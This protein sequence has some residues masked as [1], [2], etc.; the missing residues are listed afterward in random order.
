MGIF[1]TILKI[2]GI[3][4]A[5]IVGLLLLIILLV[6][7]VPVTYKVSGEYGDKIGGRVK[8]GWLFASATGNIKKTDDGM[9]GIAKLKVFGIPIKK[10]RLMGHDDT[11]DKHKV[12]P[13]KEKKNKKSGTGKAPDERTETGINGNV[14]VGETGGK[15]DSINGNESF[16]IDG[17][18]DINKE[19]D[20]I[21]GTGEETP[22]EDKTADENSGKN[23]DEDVNKTSDE[24]SEKEKVGIIEKLRLKALKILEKISGTKDKVLDKKDTLIRKKDHFIEFLDK[25][26]T[27]NTIAR[28]KKLLKK[29]FKNLLPRKGN[30]NVLFGLKTPE[31]TGAMLGKVCMFYPL[32]HKW[33]HI[34]PEFYEKKIEADLWF[35]GRIFI[36]SMA[37]PALFL[38]LSKDFKRTRNLAKKI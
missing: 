17:E 5:S 9:D 22:E 8:V 2:L 7:F 32:Y 19:I 15:A 24:D 38:V 37:I 23:A 36:G 35:K 3:V 1:L 33:L 26:Y 11:E 6:L 18:S 14:R 28:G 10:I 27:K 29:V 21:F 16:D 4:L 34:T 30:A 25:P 13:K 12:K 31:K 20:R